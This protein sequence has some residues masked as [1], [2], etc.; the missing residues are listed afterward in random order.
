MTLY[1][2]CIL[3]NVTHSFSSMQKIEPE[4]SNFPSEF[5]KESLCFDLPLPAFNRTHYI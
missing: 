1:I 3:D 2:I 5:D 4:K